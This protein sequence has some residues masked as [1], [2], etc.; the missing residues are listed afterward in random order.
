MKYT[1]GLLAGELSGSAGN[2]VASHNRGGPYFRT[3][4]IPTKSTTDAAQAAK[5]RLGALSAYWQSLPAASRLSWK[6]WADS[7]PFTD[8]LASS[9]FLTGHQAFVS[10]NTRLSCANAATIAEPPVVPA[11]ISLL[12]LSLI[13]D[14][15][16]GGITATFTETPFTGTDVL[17]LYGCVLSSP[18]VTYVKNYARL[19][20]VSATAQSSPYAFSTAFEARFGI[21]EVGNT[22]HLA[23]HVFDT[24]TGLLSPPLRASTVVVDTTV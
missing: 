22:V 6:V 5:T 19:F 8:V 7:H 20:H 23:A 15:G 1:P 9:R 14:V 2:I 17:W 3:R 12:T 4:T 11:P 24:A 13:Y 10:L 21:P 16:P 18:A